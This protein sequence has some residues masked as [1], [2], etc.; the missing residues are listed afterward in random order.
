MGLGQRK[1]RKA[2]RAKNRAVGKYVKTKRRTK[3]F[4]TVQNDY[5]KGVN[6]PVD[7]D[8]PGNGQ[9]YCITCARY[10]IDSP[11]LMSHNKSKDHKRMLKKVQT[12]EAWTENHSMLAAEMTR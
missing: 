5:I 1:S 4:E 9:F 8:L 11:S 2:G 10:F 12:E 3:D 6:L 7:L